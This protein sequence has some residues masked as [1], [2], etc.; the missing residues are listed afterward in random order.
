[1][2]KI[3]LILI[4]AALVKTEMAI[5]QEIDWVNAPQNP[6]VE[7]FTLN[8]FNLKSSTRYGF[9]V[10]FDKNGRIIKNSYGQSYNYI[11][12]QII[13]GNNRYELKD[14]LIVK[15]MYNHKVESIIEYE[16]R[17]PISYHNLKNGSREIFVYDGKGRVIESYIEIDNTIYDKLFYKYSKNADTLLVTRTSQSYPNAKPIIYKYLNGIRDQ[18]SW[19][20]IPSEVAIMDSELP[21]TLLMKYDPSKKSYRNRLAIMR[22]GDPEEFFNAFDIDFGNKVYTQYVIFD[23]KTNSYYYARLDKKKM[24]MP[25]EIRMEF[26]VENQQDIKIETLG[27]TIYLS[28]GWNLPR[29]KSFE[30]DNVSFALDQRGMGFIETSDSIVNTIKT[31]EGLEL[32]IT[33]IYRIDFGNPLVYIMDKDKSLHK[34]EIN[35]QGVKRIIFQNPVLENKDYGLREFEAGDYIYELGYPFKI[36]NIEMGTIKNIVY[37]EEKKK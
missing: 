24:N 20:T 23:E 17:R 29:T 37:S 33:S 10:A 5:A 31:S 21:M 34:I 16:N 2:K 9:N 8:H 12:N 28:R 25:Q 27:K 30:V 7:K 26:I 19:M 36:E 35:P 14:G 6:I 1:M 11:G 22:R 32:K 4:C 13:S 18:G 15:K 3:T